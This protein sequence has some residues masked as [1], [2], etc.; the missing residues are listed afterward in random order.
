MP[1]KI[2]NNKVPQGMVD[3][4]KKLVIKK[5]NFLKENFLCVSHAQTIREYL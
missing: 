1:T 4:P 5:Y 2:G 3:A